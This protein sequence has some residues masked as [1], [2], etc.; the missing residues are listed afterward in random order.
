[1]SQ[2]I[3]DHEVAENVFLFTGTSV[4]WII[5]R[6]GKD[7][8][9]IDAGWEGDAPEVERTIRLL[10]RPEDV[11]AVLLT[12]AHSDH[13]GALELLHET[14]GVP[15]W[16]S[17]AEVPNATGEH[18]EQAG[19]AD[20]VRMMY[21]PQAIRWAVDMV[22]VGGLKQITTPSA[23]SFPEEGPL[24]LPGRPVPIA[25]PG[26]TDGHTSYHLPSVGGV[27]TGDALVSGHPTLK[28]LGPRLLPGGF[29][30]DPEQAVK[31]LHV[32]REIDARMFLPGH[33]PVW[34]GSLKESV[35]EALAHVD[36]RNTGLDG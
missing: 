1:M 31:S 30:H 29:T 22:K 32:L 4:N 24:E 28:G 36:D 27:V 18:V 8:T 26:H 23:E 19:T 15:V 16:M 35:D 11:H 20:V 21:R 7:L 14:Y 3:A 17:P 13:T 2:A 25:T 33:G 9:L 5:L 10:G 6:D 12:H 34:Y